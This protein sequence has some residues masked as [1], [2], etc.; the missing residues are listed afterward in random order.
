MSYTEKPETVDAVQFTRE[1]AESADRQ[2]DA[3][4]PASEKKKFREYDAFFAD[5]ELDGTHLSVIDP[6]EETPFGRYGVWCEREKVW[7]PLYVTMW[8]VKYGR[9]D[10]FDVYTDDAFNAKYVGKA[11]PAKE[12]E[13]QK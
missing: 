3:K 2:N 7:K 8:G 5:A 1:V 6:N 12:K 9:D 11:A 4:Y 10:T 13:V